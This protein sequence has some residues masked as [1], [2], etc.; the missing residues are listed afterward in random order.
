MNDIDYFEN[1]P[2]DLCCVL[3]VGFDRHTA[4]GM[5]GPEASVVKRVERSSLEEG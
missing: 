2:Y 1:D 3:E 4:P 5:P